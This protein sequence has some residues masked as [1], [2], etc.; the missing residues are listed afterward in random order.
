MKE[1]IVADGER[2]YTA[3][4][5]QEIEAEQKQRVAEIRERYRIQLQQSGFWQRPLL[6]L[7][8]KREIRGV[9]ESSSNLY[10]EKV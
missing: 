1:K 8:M 10:F 6:K 9:L 2:R 5:R 7:R 4:N 3:A